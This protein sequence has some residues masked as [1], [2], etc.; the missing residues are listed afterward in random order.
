MFVREATQADVNRM[1]EL[2]T[3][4]AKFEDY[5]DGFAVT[6]ESV[7]NNGFGPNAC[8]HT[9]VVE[10][11]DRVIG[12]AVTYVVPWTYSLRPKLVLKELFVEEGERGSG[13]GRLLFDAVVNRAH[14]LGS[15]EIAWTVFSGNSKAERFYRAAGGTPDTK[16]ENWSYK[17]DQNPAPISKK[18]ISDD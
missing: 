5:I 14:E 2:M 3:K 4:L 11:A 17:L 7:L 15:D 18:V 13:A 10:D 6:K 12:L 16:W 1:L 9:I 8:F